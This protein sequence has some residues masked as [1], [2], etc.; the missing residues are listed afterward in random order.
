M[1]VSKR[2]KKFN[3][4]RIDAFQLILSW[5]NNRATRII[6]YFAF[7]ILLFILVLPLRIENVI[8]TISFRLSLIEMILFCWLIF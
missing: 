7:F 1:I 4:M 6:I 3:E 8:E 5:F 2:S